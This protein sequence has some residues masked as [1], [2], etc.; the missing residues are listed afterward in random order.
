MES[1]L[2]SE[3]KVKFAVIRSFVNGPIIV[4]TGPN[5]NNTVGYL[6]AKEMQV[7]QSKREKASLWICD[8][9]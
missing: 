9:L 8:I 2:A 4:E 1:A 7:R 3:R 5:L 6:Y